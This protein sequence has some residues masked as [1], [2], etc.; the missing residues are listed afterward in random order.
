MAEFP[1]QNII[2]CMIC[3]SIVETKQ[4]RIVAQLATMSSSTLFPIISLLFVAVLCVGLTLRRTS[5]YRAHINADQAIFRDH[6]SL[7]KWSLGQPKDVFAVVAVTSPAHLPERRAWQRVQWR[8]SL[9]L[10]DKLSS[11]ENPAFIFKFCVGAS[12]LSKDHV[13]TLREE[14]KLH[15]DLQMLDSPDFDVEFWGDIT[16]LGRSATTIKVL[17]ALQWAL[18]HY[19]F[20]YFVRLGDDSYFRPENFFLRFRQGKLPTD[21][22]CVGFRNGPLTYKSL[23]G[24][25]SAPYPSGMGFALTYDV[26]QWLSRASDMLL[27]GGPEDGVVG[28][29]FAGTKVQIHHMPNGFRDFDWACSPGEDIVVHCLRDQAAWSLIDNN[30]D[31]PCSS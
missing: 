31:L 11:T 10:L 23:G 18:R 20:R 29:W 22:A 15:G 4:Q 16:A 30:G 13:H 24:K 28:A 7:V 9:V 21:L 2:I 8:K 14:Q 3:P 27:L 17:A 6:A 1:V 5:A 25:V 26:V 19:K 12:N